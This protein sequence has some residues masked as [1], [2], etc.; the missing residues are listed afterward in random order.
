[1]LLKFIIINKKKSDLNNNWIESIRFFDSS[2]SEDI[3]KNPIEEVVNIL[4]ERLAFKWFLI[5][6]LLWM[7]CNNVFI[8]F[9]M[10][11]FGF[12]IVCIIIFLWLNFFPMLFIIS[13]LLESWIQINYKNEW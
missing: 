2:K 5:I 1:M 9:L 7:N 8:C 11:T 12:Q 10:E 6:S 4:S 3:R 13:F